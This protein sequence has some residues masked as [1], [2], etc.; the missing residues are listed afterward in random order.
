MGQYTDKINRISEDFK[1]L[2][3]YEQVNCLLAQNGCL[4]LMHNHGGYTV[5]TSDR[6]GEYNMHKLGPNEKLYIESTDQAY[7]ILRQ[8]YGS[9]RSPLMS[10]LYDKWQKIKQRLKTSR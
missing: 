10:R 5:T 1:K 4:V 3:S 9:D 2:E 6:P 7:L 8:R